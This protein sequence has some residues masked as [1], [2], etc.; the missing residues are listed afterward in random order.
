MT[1][2]C[3]EGGANSEPDIGGACKGPWVV[4]RGMRRR[5][6][7]GGGSGDGDGWLCDGGSGDGDGLSVLCPRGRGTRTM[8]CEGGML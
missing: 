8:S 5:S 4:E 1:A 3:K 6:V 2:A 7:C